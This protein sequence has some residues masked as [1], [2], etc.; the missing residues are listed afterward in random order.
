MNPG[1]RAPYFKPPKPRPPDV[2]VP[3]SPKRDK[4]GKVMDFLEDFLKDIGKPPPMPP[5]ERIVLDANMLCN[6]ASGGAKCYCCVVFCQ[7]IPQLDDFQTFVQRVGGMGNEIKGRPM[8]ERIYYPWRCSL[9]FS[10][11]YTIS[12]VHG[13][14]INAMRI[15][16]ETVHDGDPDVD[17][18][19]ICFY[20]VKCVVGE[21]ADCSISMKRRGATVFAE[22]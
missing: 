21:D 18:G 11:Q 5:R 6:Q 20:C 4:M 19:P 10:L 9:F 8:R 3:P 16:R 14:E 12:F 15:A 2:E 13:H 17:L 1:R 7:I 22:I